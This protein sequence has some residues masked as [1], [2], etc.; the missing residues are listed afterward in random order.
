M[1]NITQSLKIIVLALILSL[2]ISYV[3]AWTTPTVAPTGGNTPAPLNVSGNDQY[4]GDALAHTGGL[5]IEGLIRGYSNAIFDGS[6]GIGMTPISG[7]DLEVA[8][9]IKIGNQNA[10]CSDTNKGSIRY[11]PTS[12][13]LELCN[14]TKWK[15]VTLA[16]DKPAITLTVSNFTPIASTVETGSLTWS[17]TLNWSVDDATSS[18]TAGEG[19]SGVKS[20]SGGTETISPVSIATTY[21]LTCV[22]AGGTSKVRASLSGTANAY[23]SNTSLTFSPYA[24]IMVEAVGGGGGGGAGGYTESGGGGGGAGGYIRSFVS[25]GPLGTPSFSINFEGGD[26]QG[27]NRTEY[28]SCDSAAAY[29]PNGKGGTGPDTKVTIGTRVI[30]ALGGKG[31]TGGTPNVATDCDYSGESVGGAGGSYSDTST[32]LNAS[33]GNGGSNGNSGGD[34]GGGGGTGGSSKAITSGSII[35]GG[36]GGAGGVSN[37]GNGSTSGKLGAGGGGGGS[38]NKAINTSGNGGSGAAGYVIIT[39]YASSVVSVN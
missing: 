29:M 9:D 19:W 25:M 6:V 30:K 22:N 4:K 20:A 12:N 17:V 18:C 11:N 32:Y 27:G 1:N 37:G 33:N 8:G 7:A 34:G 3:F 38:R 31:G 24:K 5:G 28:S 2:G 26:G 10:T 36:T 13:V 14:G 35:Y 16:P 23:V 15:I 21:L 39:Q